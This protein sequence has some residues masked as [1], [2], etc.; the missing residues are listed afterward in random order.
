M[1]SKVNN[2]FMNNLKILSRNNNN[3]CI[4][5]DEGNHYSY[6]EINSEIDKFKNFFK[7]KTLILILSSN[8]K[9]FVINYLS[10]LKFGHTQI[11]LDENINDEFLEKILEKYN[12]EYI[13]IRKNNPKLFKNYNIKHNNFLKKYQV[14]KSKQTIKINLNKNLA[15]L[16]STSGST[17]SAKFVK[18]SFE[19]IYSNSKNI[20]KYLNLKSSD[21]S[22]TNL[23]LNY[24]YGLSVINSHFF[25]GGSMYVTNISVLEKKFWNNIFKYKVTNLNGVPYFYEILKKIKFEKFNLN[26]IKFFTQAGGPLEKKLNKFFVKFCIKNKKKFIVMYGQTEATSRISYL[27]WKFSLSK[28]GSIGKAIPG[29]LLKIKENKKKGELIYSGKNVCIGYSENYKDLNFE[30]I[31]NGTLY[32]GD[33]AKKDNEGF[34]FITGRLNR[35]IKV[36]GFR[37]NLDDLEKK[38]VLKNLHCACVGKND[39]ITVYYT[40]IN[41]KD[42]INHT[43]TNTFKF[44]KDSFNLIFIKKLPYSNNGKIQYFKLNA[45]TK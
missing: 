24:S 19:N 22:V 42:L 16:L 5:D 43:M 18:Q 34:Y 23:P 32:T 2:L 14:Y 36:F 20:S 7:K 1:N 9:E 21:K 6:K 37:I 8:T 33:I 28:I 40:S 12:P 29:G 25:A 17:G 30:D 13:F 31:N 38:L 39:F 27:P 26:Y 4:V 15:V 11:I 3:L 44:K 45:V 35:N 41:Q 10:F